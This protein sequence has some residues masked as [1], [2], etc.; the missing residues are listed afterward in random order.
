MIESKGSKVAKHIVMLLSVSVYIFVILSA[1]GH[2]PRL[3]NR[4]FYFRVLYNDG[5][6]ESVSMFTRFVTT[7]V[8][9]LCKFIHRQEPRVQGAHHHHQDAVGSARDA[10]AGAARLPEE[11]R[12]G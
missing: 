12:G 4:Q 11:A 10:Q 7:P 3:E 9:F 8:L 5:T 6:V 1:F 2:I